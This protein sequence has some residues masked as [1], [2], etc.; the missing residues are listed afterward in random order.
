MPDRN[1]AERPARMLLAELLRQE[2]TTR[3]ERLTLGALWTRYETEC[4][5][6]LENKASTRRDDAARVKLLLAFFGE[7]SDVRTLTARDQSAYAACARLVASSSRTVARL[8]P[9]ARVRLRWTSCCFI[10]C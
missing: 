7:Q 2:E 6:Y 4:A 9:C 8:G 10:R 1:E 5:T 3:S